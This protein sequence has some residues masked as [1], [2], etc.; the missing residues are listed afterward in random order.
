M[1]RFLLNLLS[2]A[3]LAT[4]QSPSI[5][6][7]TQVEIAN[8][9]AFQ[10]ISDV[11]DQ[12]M[13]QNIGGRASA[14]CTYANADVRREWRTLPRATRKA[15]TDAVT[16]LQKMKPRRMTVGQAKAYPGVKSR[17]D[18]YVATHINYTYNIHDTAD[19][20]AW[21]RGFVHFLEQDLRDLCGYPGV[22]PYWNWSE[23]AEAPQNSPLFSGDAYSM[24]SNGK[25][26]A[27]R[28][29]TWLAQQDI[30]YPPGLGGG[31]VQR[32]PFTNYT[33]NL[34]PLSL[35]GNKNVAS[36]FQYNP[37]CLERDINPWFSKRFTTYTNL[38]TLVLENIYLED[39]QDLSQG[40]GSATNK[41]GVHGGGHWQIGG[42]MMDFNSSPSDP[43][44]FLHH[45]MT[46]R[47]WL[48]WQY[49][50]IWNRQFAISGTATL[51]CKS[52][53]CP[54]MTLD[55]KLPFGFVAPDQTFR[56]LMDTMA[57]PLCYRY[58]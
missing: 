47:M 33:V 1:R 40:Y 4:A 55:D 44:F 11:A 26:V 52:P 6:S 15:F 7:F 20:F 22:M 57:G 31:C 54:Q 37:R 14:S 3:T 46:D 8:G 56:S 35:P 13:R 50:D 41:F 58:E 28:T 18:E 2:F 48:I 29:D 9:D 12:R 24:G 27:G 30:V 25:F 10:N 19:F 16:C 49:L 36:M 32:G 17:Y 5:N 21:H 53:D 34:G 51:G 38:T 39:F 42:S 43:L 45:S 23:D